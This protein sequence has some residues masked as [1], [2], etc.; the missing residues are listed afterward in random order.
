MQ[1]TIKEMKPFCI[2]T[3]ID[4][5]MLQLFFIPPPSHQRLY[6]ATTQ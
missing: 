2:V 3:E 1:V 6:L 4:G 5:F